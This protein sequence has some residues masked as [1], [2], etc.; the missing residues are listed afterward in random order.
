MSGPFFYARDML[1]EFEKKVARFVER[2]ELLSSARKVVLAA[3]GGADST[4]LLYAMQALTAEKIF[5]AELLCA[6]VNHQLRGE[7]A[8]LDEAFVLAQAAELNLAAAARRVDVRGFA[9]QN[10]LSIETAAR[11][12][13]IGALTEIARENHCDLIATAHQKN[14]NAET[15]LQRLARGTG[16]RGLAGIWPMRVFADGVPFVRPLLSVSRDEILGYLRER[17]VQWR[18]DTTNADCTYRRNYIRHQLLPAL[19]RDCAG[20]V[21]EQLSELAQRAR[22]FQS[23]IDRR[24]D[25]L[26]PDVAECTGEQ[27]SLDLRRFATQPHALQIELVRRSLTGIGSGERDLAQRHYECI[28]R[29]AQQDVTSGK[30]ELPGGFFVQREYGNLMFTRLGRKAPGDERA[31]QPVRLEIPGRTRFGGYVIEATILEARN[32]ELEKFIPSKTDRVERFDLEKVKLPL[33]V[34]SRRAGDRFVPLGLGKE[35]KLGKFLTDQRIPYDV[36][37]RVLVVSDSEKILWVWPIRIS[38][39][40]KISSDTRRILQLQ[41]TDVES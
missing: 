24:A 22:G 39:E 10:K 20:S 18:R 14:D 38:D 36:R 1:S 16:F 19:Q 30:M 32:A 35:K 11:Q 41:I 7:E 6:H 23:L 5:N 27:T 40:A 13:R 31:G 26:W 15:V 12:L 37:R 17:N 8:D 25:Q 21:V 28:L 3:S 29:L 9:R 4:A 34:R 2:H 33:Q